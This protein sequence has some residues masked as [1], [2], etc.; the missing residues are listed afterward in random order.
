MLIRVMTVLMSV[1][2]R[3]WGIL[4]LVLEL[5]ALT[6][7]V[8]VLIRVITNLTGVVTRISEILDF[9]LELTVRT[10][11]FLVLIR[12]F[13]VLMTVSYEDIGDTGFCFVA[14]CTHYTDYCGR[15]GS[16]CARWESYEDLGD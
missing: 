12:I 15:S 7:V 1:V 10:R 8:I 5:T 11:V 2:T 3:I 4:E 14:Y 13:T 6:K 16:D 9:I